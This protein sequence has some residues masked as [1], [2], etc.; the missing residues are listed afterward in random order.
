LI[1]TEIKKLDDVTRE[2]VLAVAKKYLVK[3]NRVVFYYVPKGTKSQY[4]KK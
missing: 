2:D 3:D 1:N 4:L